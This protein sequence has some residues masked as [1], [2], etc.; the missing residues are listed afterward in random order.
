[1]TYARIRRVAVGVAVVAALGTVAAC[2]PGGGKAAQGSQGGHGTSPTGNGGPAVTGTLSALRTAAA[3]TGQADSAKV[4]SS[5]VYD[6]MSITMN[7]TLAWQHGITG[8]LDVAMTGG[9][10]ASA[11]KQ[12]GGDGTLRT[13]YLTNAA[14]VDLGQVIAEA[15]GGKP[16][17]RYDYDTLTKLMGASGS[18]FKDQFQNNSPTQSVQMLIGSGDV[19]AVGQETVRGV[20]TTHYQGTVDIPKLVGSQSGL[21]PATA[22]RLKSQL[23]AQGITTDHVD[24]WVNGQGLLVKKAER[25]STKSGSL[26]ST[27]YYSDY[28]VKVTVAAPPAGQTMDVT[29]LLG[30]Q[31]KTA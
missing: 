22:K 20:R 1:M 25:A 8:D 7:G 15:D 31:G 18:A 2:G 14:Y 19:K 13:R 11:F 5:T 27:A 6:G 28:G 12:L 24:V 17:L 29:E 3:K 10:L 23:Q 4:D 30:Q 9:K 21:D 26:T 16:W